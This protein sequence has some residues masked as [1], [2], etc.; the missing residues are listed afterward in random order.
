[1]DSLGLQNHPYKWRKEFTLGD[2]TV[3]YL[4]GIPITGIF[5]DFWVEDEA[6]NYLY[7]Y[8]SSKLF[9]QLADEME[10]QLPKEG[11]TF[12]G[13]TDIFYDYVINDIKTNKK[14]MD[15]GG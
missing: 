8:P 5:T 2:G 13:V 9:D 1:M 4:C 15:N 6:G 10:K 7:S 14:G 11:Y 3:Q 12:F